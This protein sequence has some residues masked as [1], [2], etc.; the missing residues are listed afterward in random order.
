MFNNNDIEYMKLAIELAGKA[1]GQTTPN[2]MVGAVI[3]K[4]GRIIGEG[5]HKKAGENHAEI[6]ALNSA[7]TDKINGSTM[8]VSLEPCCHH[9]KTPPC[10]EAVIKSGI[11]EVII[12]AQDPNPLVSGMGI[13]LLK[14]NG[15]NIKVGLLETEARKLNEFFYMFHENA[16][17]FII[18]KWAMTLDGRTS[19]D[20]GD[21]KWISND[22]SRQYVHY[23]RS[24]VDAVMVAIGTV[25][26]DDPTLNCRLEGYVGK[27]PKRI[28]VDPSCKVPLSFELFLNQPAGEIIIITTKMATPERI[29]N[30]KD[31]G[32]SIIQFDQ[33][34]GRIKITD[35]LKKLAERNIQS[36][37]VEGGRDLTSS[38]FSEDLVDKVICF[39]AP[40]ILGGFKNTSPINNWGMSSMEE[41]LNL[42]DV[43]IK[44]FD[45]DICIEGYV[46]K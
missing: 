37:M 41:V 46:R 17:P 19:S 34:G 10:A 22:L 44:T 31:K 43:N 4:D 7:T 32:C 12:A 1:I 13:E 25:I 40:K 5:Y 11:K 20:S 14:K 39:V 16:R 24:T 29:K 27:Q 21:S 26:K 42:R 38:F 33:Q 36:I 9:G 18:A 15:I 3:V 45:K 35:I 6:E 30:L 8:Y 2:P 28:I 23:V